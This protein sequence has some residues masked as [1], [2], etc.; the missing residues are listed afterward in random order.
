MADEVSSELW[1]PLSGIFGIATV[2]FACLSLIAPAALGSS[3]WLVC[4]CAVY[5]LY[6]RFS[7][8]K[9]G[10]P[11]WGS[12]EA[13]GLGATFAI[14]QLMRFG[15]RLD[16]VW[17]R[18]LA[19]FFLALVLLVVSGAVPT[20]EPSTVHFDG[21]TSLPRIALFGLLTFL[22][23][24][25]SGRG[26]SSSLGKGETAT[27]RVLVAILAPC[28][29]VLLA[30]AAMLLRWNELN[31]DGFA[32]GGYATFLADPRSLLAAA[33]A[34]GGLLC[35]GLLGTN[36]AFTA[37]TKKRDPRMESFF[38]VVDPGLIRSGERMLRGP[39]LATDWLSA[40]LTAETER[41]AGMLESA[42]RGFLGERLF[43][44]LSDSSVSLSEFVRL[45]HSGQARTYLF[46]GVLVTLLASAAFLWEGR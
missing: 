16:L 32:A 33:G 43:R 41:A 45:V 28:F 1:L 18:I 22:V 44:R 46:V 37:W 40:R 34:V 31:F 26:F 6:L 20:V 12:Y 11:F 17:K 36:K 19:F 10:D 23:A 42:D 13:L 24:A 9:P 5:L 14:S 4:T 2:A 3:F 25:V 30:E 15:E 7:S 21:E 29:L 8:A 27:P 38:P 35:G 39:E